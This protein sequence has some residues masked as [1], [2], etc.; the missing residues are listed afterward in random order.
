M[1]EIAGQRCKLAGVRQQRGRSERG[2]TLIEVLVVLA[3]LSLVVSTS[4]WLSPQRRLAGLVTQT[5]TDIEDLIIAARTEA[6]ASYSAQLVSFDLE[7]RTVF[8]NDR[9]LVIPAPVSVELVT[10]AEVSSDRRNILFFADGSGSGG[11]ITVSAQTITRRLHVSWLT[12]S[13]SHAR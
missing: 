6:A 8:H 13:V 4:L 12:G 7:R 10:A 3:I 11:T 1:R 9:K 2:F 5:L